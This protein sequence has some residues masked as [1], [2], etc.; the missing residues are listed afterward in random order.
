MRLGL[1]ELL[2]LGPMAANGIA[3]TAGI[4][5]VS[6]AP[7]RRKGAETGDGT[8]RNERKPVSAGGRFP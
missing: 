5:V 3:V 8:R 1:G 6:L 2:V 7:A 4:L